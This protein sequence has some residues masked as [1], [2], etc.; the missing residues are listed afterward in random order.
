MQ[1]NRV[2]K[3]RAKRREVREK[4]KQGTREERMQKKRGETAERERSARKKGGECMHKE[5]SESEWQEMR[6]CGAPRDHRREEQ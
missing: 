4:E 1:E 2:K 3:E 5:G 6:E